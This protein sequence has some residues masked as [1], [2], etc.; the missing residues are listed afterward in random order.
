MLVEMI[1][2]VHFETEK[3]N[4]NENPKLTPANVH[5]V[6]VPGPINAAVNTTEGPMLSRNFFIPF[7][8]YSK[9][10]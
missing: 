9:H 5:T 4:N 1:K 3:T 10:I 8:K 6:I 7:S 2:I